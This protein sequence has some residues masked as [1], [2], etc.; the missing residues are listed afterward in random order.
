MLFRSCDM[1]CCETTTYNLWSRHNTIMCHCNYFCSGLHGSTT[2]K[3]QIC[4]LH[5]YNVVASLHSFG[6]FFVF[7]VFARLWKCACTFLLYLHKEKKVAFCNIIFLFL[8]F[9]CVA[10]RDSQFRLKSCLLV[11]VF[12]AVSL[13]TSTPEQHTSGPISFWLSSDWQSLANKWFEQLV[14]WAAVLT[15]WPY[16]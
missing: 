2:I 15:G 9:A 5:R 12:S 7:V 8:D 6:L 10:L 1:S 14:G 16:Y 11:L 3:A 13:S 4:W